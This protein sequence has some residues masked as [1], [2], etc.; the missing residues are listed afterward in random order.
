MT[1]TIANDREHLEGLIENAFEDNITNLNF[2][3]TS[4]ITDMSALFGYREEDFDVS[5]WHVSNVTDMSEMFAD[6]KNFNSDISSWDVNNVVNMSGMFSEAENFNAD[7]SQ[8][9]VSQATDMSNMFYKATAFNQDIGNWDVS[10]VTSMHN[11]FGDAKSFNQD[12]NKWTVSNVT[13]MSFMFEGA[14]NF[15]GKINDW[16]V[17]RVEDMVAVFRGAT[18]FNQDISRWDVS[19][20]TDMQGMFSNAINFNQPINIWNVSNVTDMRAMFFK[21]ESFNQD[22]SHWDVSNV[23]D[24][25]AMFENAKSFNADIS[26]WNVSQVAERDDILEGATNFKHSIDNWDDSGLTM[27]Q[28]FLKDTKPFSLPELDNLSM[29]ITNTKYVDSLKN[30]IEYPNYTYWFYNEN[31]N[32]YY[33]WYIYDGDL[34]IDEAFF[35][36]PGVSVIVAGNLT[37]RGS[38][39]DTKSGGRLIVLGDMTVDNIISECPFVVVGDVHATGLTYFGYNDHSGEVTGS[40]NAN[41]YLQSDRDFGVMGDINAKL[42]D[43]ENFRERDVFVDDVLD[44]DDEEDDDYISL[45][46]WKAEDWLK[47]CKSIFRNKN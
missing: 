37:V 7:I 39:A 22:I 32:E 26:Q 40:V 19:Q 36:L 18:N 6:A 33:Q 24:M 46:T 47:E 25:R 20:I 9:N 34:V 30:V 17:S 23:T 10:Q 15:N 44:I 45:D 16:D 3:D 11:M 5:Q 27:N 29:L 8:W 38:Y 13:Y 1:K 14:K 41:Y 35:S 12:L 42:I 31:F 43:Y 21:A 2:I 28:G 4:A